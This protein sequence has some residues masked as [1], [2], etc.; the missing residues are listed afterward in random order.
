MGG[1]KKRDTE[2]NTRQDGSGKR[3]REERAPGAG[4]K[5][6]IGGPTRVDITRGCEDVSRG[7]A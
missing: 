6:R 2:L 1:L 3:K 7:N 5:V 4:K